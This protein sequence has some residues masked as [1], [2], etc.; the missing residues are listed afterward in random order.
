MVALCKLS[1]RRLSAIGAIKTLV[2]GRFKAQMGQWH[3]AIGIEFTKK[4]GNFQPFEY[5]RHT[6]QATNRFVQHH[7]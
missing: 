5:D 3:G 4:A 6:F 7:G 2:H 1:L